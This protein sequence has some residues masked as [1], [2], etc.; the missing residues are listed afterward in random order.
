[1]KKYVKPTIEVF[2]IEYE[3]IL[4]A[5]HYVQCDCYEYREN[6]GCIGCKGHCGCNHW[7]PDLQEIVPGC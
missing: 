5:S 3:N 7:D 1:M 2:K 6:G 4:K